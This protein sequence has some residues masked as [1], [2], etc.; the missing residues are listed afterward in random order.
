VLYQHQSQNKDIF[1]LLDFGCGPQSRCAMSLNTLL[2]TLKGVATNLKI[3]ATFLDLNCYDRPQTLGSSSVGVG[4]GV[5]VQITHR[6]IQRDY[7]EPGLIEEIGEGVFDIIWMLN[8]ELS[9]GKVQGTARN[10]DAAA[11]RSALLVVG[12]SNEGMVPAKVQLTLTLVITGGWF[13]KTLHGSGSDGDVMAPISLSRGGKWFY[14]V[15]VHDPSWGS[16]SPELLETHARYVEMLQGSP[17]NTRPHSEDGQG[18]EVSEIYALCTSARALGAAEAATTAGQERADQ[19]VLGEEVRRCNA[20]KSQAAQHIAECG[21]PT[22]F[23]EVM[24]SDIVLGPGNHL[25]RGPGRSAAVKWFPNRMPNLLPFYGGHTVQ[26]GGQRK[27]KHMRDIESGKHG[28][29]IVRTVAQAVELIGGQ[30]KIVYRP[31]VRMVFPKEIPVSF[32]DS[33]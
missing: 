11:A 13:V 22:D 16:E 6:F 27:E 14:A 9:K 31:I 21:A 18:P 1:H 17:Y 7:S 26:T 8:S 3:F 28:N 5:G 23:M 20:A 25:A 32:S 10:I 19:H 24:A 33:P 29:S 12:T 15:M 4:V 30:E 2:D